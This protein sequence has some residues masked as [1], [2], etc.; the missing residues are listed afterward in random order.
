[1]Y[2]HTVLWDEKVILWDL[3]PADP[4]FLLSEEL[5]Y[6]VFGINS[7]GYGTVLSCLSFYAGFLVRRS[8]QQTTT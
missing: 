3:S 4:F 6:Y 8:L 5:P 7:I 1:M 2:L